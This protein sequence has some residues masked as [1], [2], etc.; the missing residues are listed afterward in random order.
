MAVENFF[1]DFE[2]GAAYSHHWGRTLTE[3][4]SLLFS[5]VTMQFNPMYFNEEYARHL[6]YRG[7]VVNPS[8]ILA[9]VLG[10]SVE[11]N[12]EG[13]GLFLGMTKVRFRG[14]VYARDT[15]YAESRVLDKR[16]SHSRSGWGIVTWKTV[17]YNQLGEEV[18]EFERS[19]LLPMKGK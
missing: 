12:S 3:S 15:L 17:G 6:G 11:D 14:T 7:I 5:T 19:N 9:T 8:L 4:D 18:V 1:E 13:A 2:V 16:K 10:L